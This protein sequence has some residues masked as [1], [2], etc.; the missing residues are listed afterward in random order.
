MSAYFLY[1]QEIHAIIPPE[2]WD[3]A[4]FS[5][6]SLKHAL[7]GVPGWKRLDL[8]ANNQED[9]TIHVRIITNWETVEQLETW[10]ASDLTVEGLLKG[11]TPPPTE[12]QTA[13]YEKIS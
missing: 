4:Y 13:F 12:I 11:L 10:L 6:L 3:E 9:N 5:L 7:A 2:S 1:S 8:L